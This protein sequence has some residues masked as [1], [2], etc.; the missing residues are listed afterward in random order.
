MYIEDQGQ[1]R[2]I[3]GP[4]PDGVLWLGRE[5]WV[6]LTNY[7][8]HDAN[9]QVVLVIDRKGRIYRN[10]EHICPTLFL[11]SPEGAEL[12]S[13]DA[14][15]K[16]QTDPGDG[17][18]EWQLIDDS[19]A[20][21]DRET[22]PTALEHE[23]QVAAAG[24]A[25]AHARDLAVR[26]LV[27]EG[28][29]ESWAVVEPVLHGST[30]WQLLDE[31]RRAAETAGP[32]R[33]GV[34]HGMIDASLGTQPQERARRLAAAVLAVDTQESLSYLLSLVGDADSAVLRT[35]LRDAAEARREEGARGARAFAPLRNA[36]AALTALD[37][38]S[39]AALFRSLL[40]SSDQW[41]RQAGVYGVG[42]L[43]LADTVGRL[44][45]MLDRDTELSFRPGAVCVALGK[46]G[47]PE[48]YDAL[49]DLASQ[50]PVD[51]VGSYS[52]L[53][54]VAEMYGDP[55]RRPYGDWSNGCWATAPAD[56]PATAARFA[57][58]LTR[59]SALRGG[60]TLGQKARRQASLLLQAA[61]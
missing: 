45:T 22:L 51:N 9:P 3:I 10:F 43:R 27:R 16:T 49:V 12:N 39:A 54:V 2:L 44:K 42:E 1:G 19:A 46:I 28:S 21:P 30:D 6:Y 29:D 25:S 36:V 18:P 58:A 48:A 11:R 60:S 24:E 15:L 14:F 23:M 32:A 20:T 61:P 57:Q 33:V 5:D 56:E 55:E 34:V 50:E 8:S 59:I 53:G 7:W 26:A 13:L 37:R 17:P 41:Q 35:A 40:D 4:H 38:E 52:V 47:S 31:A